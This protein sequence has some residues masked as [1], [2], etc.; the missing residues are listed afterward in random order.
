MR[1]HGKA[2][3]DARSPRALAICDRCGFTF[4]HYTLNWQYQWAGNQLQD[5]GALVCRSCMDTPQEQLRTIVLP[6]D[7]IPI[8]NARPENYQNAGNPQ[9][10]VGTAIGTLTEFAGTPS[11]FDSN[12]NKPTQMGAGLLTSNSSYDNSIGVYWGSSNAKAVYRFALYAPN[13]QTFLAGAATGYKLQGGNTGITWTDIYTSTSAGTVGESIDV[14]LDS[15]IATT[16]YLY[17]QINLNGDGT[18]TIG[19]AQCQFY[20][21]G[22]SG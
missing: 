12:T 11:A 4:N 18:T 17:H 6:A 13:D 7:P 5:Q 10:A 16:S 8:M 9:S 3:I 20:V 22:G 19:V 15:S 21:L 1:P 2:R 14:T